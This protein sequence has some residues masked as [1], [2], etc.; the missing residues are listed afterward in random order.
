MLGTQGVRLDNS[1]LA[2]NDISQEWFKG[3][4]SNNPFSQLGTCSSQ[5]GVTK[6]YVFRLGFLGLEL[7]PLSSECCLYPDGISGAQERVLQNRGSVFEGAAL[8][9]FLWY[10]WEA[11]WSRL[12]QHQKKLVVRANSPWWQVNNGNSKQTNKWKRKISLFPPL[13][14]LLFPL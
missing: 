12:W 14:C 8:S 7:R 9:G 5:L 13:S 1:T 11:Q 10:E 4:S 6:S 2:I 3:T